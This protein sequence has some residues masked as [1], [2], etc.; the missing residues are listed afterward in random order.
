M[1]IQ[2]YGHSAF[3]LN[4]DEGVHIITDPYQSGAYG[5]VLSYGPITDPADIVLVS[6]G[7]ADHNH[8]GDIPKG[9]SLIDKTGDYSV[10]GLVIHAIPVYHDPS[11]GRDRGE[12]LIFVIETDG[13]RIAHLGDLGHTLDKALLD[14][15]G[16]ID[17]LMIPV[18]G[19]F[20]IDAQEATEVMNDIGPVITIPMHF[21]TAKADF[22]IKGVDLFTKGKK[23]VRKL[24]GSE[25]AITKAE[26]PSEP[27]V[28]I[29]DY[30]K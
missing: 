26:L 2:W 24:G 7:H 13:M 5:G 20:T 4:T 3:H 27:E 22:P 16:H 6:H 30:A 15:I 9:F 21:K 8:T 25:M 29:F 17:I 11:G 10:K 12:N 18:G 1:K 19:F 23:H 14:K 28:V